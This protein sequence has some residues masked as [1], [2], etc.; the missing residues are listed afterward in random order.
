[1]RRPPIPIFVFDRTQ[2]GWKVVEIEPSQ[3]ATAVITLSGVRFHE[4]AH[5][6][7]VKR[8]SRSNKA[9]LIG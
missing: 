1:M 5:G 7:F 6:Y 9:K 2:I 8:S 3:D 4:H